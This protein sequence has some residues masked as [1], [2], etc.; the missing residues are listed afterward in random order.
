MAIGTAGF[1]AMLAV[2]ALEEQGRRR[3]GEVVVT[4]AAGGVGSVAIPLLARAGYKVVASSG[5]AELEDYLKRLGATEFVGRR[6]S[7]RAPKRRSI[8]HAGPAR[9]TSVGGDTLVNL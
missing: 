2:L 8:P 3:P 9:S 1:T 5:R 6:R 7:P 4:G